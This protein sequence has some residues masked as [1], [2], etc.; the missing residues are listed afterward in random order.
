VVL[1]RPAERFTLKTEDGWRYVAR[2]AASR[3][4]LRARL[5]LIHWSVMRGEAADRH[6]AAVRWLA[7]A[8]WP[9]RKRAGRGGN[10]AVPDRGLRVGNGAGGVLPVGEL[11]GFAYNRNDRAAGDLRMVAPSTSCGDRFPPCRVRISVG[12]TA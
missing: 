7:R 6:S 10:G 9:A 8:A 11:V 5:W 4:L 12:N 2:E 1:L 3:A